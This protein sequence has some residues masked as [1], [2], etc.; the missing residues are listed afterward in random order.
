VIRRL[1]VNPELVEPRKT[2]ISIMSA[3]FAALPQSRKNLTPQ[4]LAEFLNFYLSEMT[5]IVFR[6]QGTLD[7]YIGDAVMAFG[8]R[9]SRSQEKQ[10]ARANARWT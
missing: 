10:F 5:R 2:E 3:T 6:R 7:K 1:L 9:R 8:A 4:D